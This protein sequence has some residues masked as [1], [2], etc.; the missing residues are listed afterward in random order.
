MNILIT[1]GAGFIGS[2]LAEYLIRHKQH[3]YIVDDLSTGSIDNLITIQNS[4]FLHFFKDSLLNESLINKLI[5]CVDHIYHLAATVGVQLVLQ[6]PIQTIHNN[7][8][9]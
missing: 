1:G 3:V 7:L 6:K 5:N 9:L 4:P 2:H 8:F